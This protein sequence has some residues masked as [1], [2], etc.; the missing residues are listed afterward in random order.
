MSPKLTTAISVF[1]MVLTMYT[2]TSNSMHVDQLDVT[3]QVQVAAQ[4]NKIQA[5]MLSIGHLRKIQHAVTLE[6]LKI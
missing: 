3:F 2:N 5:L 1:A 6:I 4:K